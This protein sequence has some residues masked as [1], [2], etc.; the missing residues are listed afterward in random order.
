M[1]IFMDYRRGRNAKQGFPKPREV[2]GPLTTLSDHAQAISR[3]FQ[4]IPW[5]IEET[6]MYGLGLDCVAIFRANN[7]FQ[8]YTFLGIS[9]YWIFCHSTKMLVCTH[10]RNNH[11]RHSTTLCITG[12]AELPD[13]K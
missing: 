2:H 6:A 5:S 9:L 13:G 7:Y 3:H 4:T 8:C 12:K 10:R 11:S 1:I